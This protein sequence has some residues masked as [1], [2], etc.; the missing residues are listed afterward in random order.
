MYCPTGLVEDR[1][2]GIK[3]LIAD[4]AG[5]VE[6]HRNR[7]HQHFL[8]EQPAL[9]QNQQRTPSRESFR[10]RETVPKG[11]DAEVVEKSRCGK[12]GGEDGI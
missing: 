8:L 5:D 3:N 4:V 10:F 11:L 2:P 6:L 1:R 9:I 12:S 7:S